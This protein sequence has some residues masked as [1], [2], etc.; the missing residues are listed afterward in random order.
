MTTDQFHIEM[1]DISPFPLERSA[2]YSFWEETSFEELTE[3]ILVN[4][5]EEKQK[6]F[7]GV[8]R[9]GSTFRLTNYYY[10]IKTN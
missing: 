10:R 8:V 7:F 1:E 5:T 3:N 2:D 9:N 4:L 6:L